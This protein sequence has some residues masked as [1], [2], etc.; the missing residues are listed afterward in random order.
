MAKSY[1]LI[2]G[3]NLMHAAGM[4]RSS[5]GPG[6]LERC[7]VRFLKYLLGHLNQPELIRTTVVFDAANAPTDLPR[8][9]QLQGMHILF[10]DPGSD[11]DSMIEQ[12]I[13]KH[14]A[15]R[16]IRLVSSDH[17][18]QK[19][20]RRRRASFV[21]SEVFVAELERRDARGKKN[22][23]SSQQRDSPKYSGELTT[24]ETQEWLRVFGDVPEADQLKD[25]ATWWQ[26]RI[27]DQ[28]DELDGW[29]DDGPQ[30]L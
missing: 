10:A 30:S 5:Y 12:L 14:S 26:A 25:E 20:A 7:R 24:E 16:Q 8:R 11:A 9:T 17:R 3:Y 29:A 15:P 4:A 19:A 27:D 23:T 21:D 18:L 28:D 1:L 6:D 13:A 22:E 2:D